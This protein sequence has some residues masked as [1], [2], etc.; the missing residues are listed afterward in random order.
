MGLRDL[1]NKKANTPEVIIA[2]ADGELID[3][4]T[5]N[6]STFAQKMLGESIAFRYQGDMVT[7]CAPCSGELTA[8]FPTG[9]AFGITR[10]DGVELLVHIGINTVEANGD[11]F[12]ILNKKQGQSVEAGDPIVKV[13]LTKLGQNY[14]MATMLIITNA[15][16]KQITFKQPC[17]VKCGE[18]VVV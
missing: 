6:D 4:T 13:D 9:H 12:E 1:L 7:I 8:L 16:Q 3:V 2:M 18:S 11:G 17:T 15:N 14:D 10:K 5:V